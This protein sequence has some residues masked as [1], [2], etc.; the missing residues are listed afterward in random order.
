MSFRVYH[1]FISVLLFFLLHNFAAKQISHNR[2]YYISASRSFKTTTATA[3]TTKIKPF[4]ID[5]LFRLDE[6]SN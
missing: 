4:M 3:T 5:F 1:D 2:I 6:A